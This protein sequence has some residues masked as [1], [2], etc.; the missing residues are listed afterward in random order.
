MSL[1]LYALL[2]GSPAGS[3]GT[4]AAG[5]PVRLIALDGLLAAV[6]EVV[7]PPA[8]ALPALR[9]H[10]ALLRRL[11][12]EVD[13]V[14]P[15]R[16]GTVVPDAPALAAALAPRRAALA[17]ALARVAGCAQ[18]TLR[19]WGDRGAADDEVIESL[20]PAGAVGPGARY[21]AARRE[22]H[23]RAVGLPDLAPLRERV[24][25]LVRA[26]QVERHDAPPLLATVQHLV[27]RPATAAYLAAVQGMPAGRW[28]LTVT[29]PWVPYAF[30]AEVTA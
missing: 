14:L 6:G 9:A 16:F 3:P 28:R 27:P 10:D 4:G 30:A 20:Q 25:A 8:V 26:E 17:G 19:L 2:D 22:V 11:A 13:A 29:G 24:D 12:G 23:R 7:E 18:M 1:C 5:E 21:L 15:V